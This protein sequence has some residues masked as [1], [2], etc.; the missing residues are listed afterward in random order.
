MLRLVPEWVALHEN[1]AVTDNQR[2]ALILCAAE[3][4]LLPAAHRGPVTTFLAAWLQ[5]ILLAH[6]LCAE[7]LSRF[8]SGLAS[9]DYHRHPYD[10]RQWTALHDAELRGA[11]DLQEAFK[12]FPG[13]TKASVRR[14]YR[15]LRRV[16]PPPR[17]EGAP[18]GLEA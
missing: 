18:S 11:V 2:A 17:E 1:G 13:K 4:P 15:L 8:S 3:F 14:R 7:Q 9:L 16:P 10:K 12:L 5:E 6:P